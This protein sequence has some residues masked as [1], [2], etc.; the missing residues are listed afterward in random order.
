MLDI[1]VNS[2]KLDTTSV[3]QNLKLTNPFNQ[4]CRLI[5]REQFKLQQHIVD[6]K[7]LRNNPPP[8]KNKRRVQYVT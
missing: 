7:T 8:K 4:L 5:L 3:S 6:N 2:Y 1:D